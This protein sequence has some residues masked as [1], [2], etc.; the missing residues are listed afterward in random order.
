MQ[1][2]GGRKERHNKD[3]PL[4]ATM[5][6]RFVTRVSLCQDPEGHRAGVPATEVL[7]RFHVQRDQH[8]RRRTLPVSPPAAGER[9]LPVCRRSRPFRH[10]LKETRGGVTLALPSAGAVC[11]GKQLLPAHPNAPRS[12]PA[13][14]PQKERGS[15]SGRSHCHYAQLHHCLSEAG[16]ASLLPYPPPASPE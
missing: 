13:T 2:A 1:P 15:Q 6:S 12:G 10:S 3:C 11:P 4:P 9:P 16:Y 5:G 8:G 14:T 7:G